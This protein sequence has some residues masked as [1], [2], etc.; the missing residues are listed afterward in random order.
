LER[1]LLKPHADTLLGRIWSAGAL[2]S[3][4]V[5]VRHHPRAALHVAGS[6]ILQAAKA[7]LDEV[8]HVFSARGANST[9]EESTKTADRDGS[10]VAE[11]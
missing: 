10:P 7:G 5:L 9:S 1:F 6:G 11:N 3:A 4:S 8:T 2:R